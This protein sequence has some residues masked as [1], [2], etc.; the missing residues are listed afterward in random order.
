MLSNAPLLKIAAIDKRLLARWPTNCARVW[1]HPRPIT[2]QSPQLTETVAI[3][4]GV[5]TN[6]DV[7]IRS[8]LSMLRQRHRP[9]IGLLP[10]MM[11][12]FTNR[13]THSLRSEARYLCD[14]SRISGDG[15]E[16][17]RAA[18]RATGAAA[19]CEGSGCHPAPASKSKAGLLI[20]VGVAF[21]LF[22]AL[23]VGGFLY[24]KSR[25]NVSGTT[26]ANVNTPWRQWR[27]V[28]TGS[29][30][31]QRLVVDDES[32]GLVPI[33]SGSRSISFHFQRGRLS[34]H[35]WSR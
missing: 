3:E 16:C 7:G 6:S 10:H 33:A 19:S 32:S 21:V 14:R 8:L 23:G 13:P 9:S 28:V 22:V 25:S 18:S 30:S 29:S 11:R 26:T 5:Q 17:D 20:G 12:P 31:N 4:R 15:V 34:L 1:K 2:G 24:W 35:L 27:S